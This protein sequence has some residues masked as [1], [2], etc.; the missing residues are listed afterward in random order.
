MKYT[1]QIPFWVGGTLLLASPVLNNPKE[2]ALNRATI[3]KRTL[4]LGIASALLLAPVLVSAQQGNTDDKVAQYE[5]AIQALQSQIDQLKQEVAK[6]KEAQKPAPKPAPAPAKP[7]TEVYGFLQSQYETTSGHNNSA[8]LVRRARIGVRGTL[9]HNFNY[10]ILNSFEDGSNAGNAGGVIRNAFIEYRG[11]GHSA[12][13]P[14][15]RFGQFKNA[16]SLE[17]LEDAAITP[18]VERGIA[19]EQLA[20]NHDRDMGIGLYTPENPNRSYAYNVSVMNG[21]GRNRPT[22]A[23]TKLVTARFQLNTTE[24][25]P[26]LHGNLA[27]GFSTRQGSVM[28]LNRPVGSQQENEHYGIDLEYKN[29]HFRTRAEYLWAR[30]GANHRE[31]FYTMLGYHL[32]HPVELLGR[33]EGYSPNTGAP[34]VHRTTLGMT[35]FFSKVT[36]AYLNYEFIDGTAPSGQSSGLRLRLTTRFP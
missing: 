16:Y 10:A 14:V 7:R 33:Y 36:E 1:A 5:K 22:A 23:G 24:K 32:S 3:Y 2:D 15:L 27:L 11:F 18:F 20:V 30:D 35:Y 29:R 28:N 8:F 25:H 31:G 9:D 13:T 19:V 4:R 17:A 34:S 26:F 12:S 21:S 6:V